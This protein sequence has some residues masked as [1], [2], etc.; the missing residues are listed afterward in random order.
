[1]RKVIIEIELTEHDE[2]SEVSESEQLL[3]SEARRAVD[4][5][6]APYSDFKVGAAVLLDSGD[7]VLGSNQ[8]NAAYPSGLCAERVA[9]FA[10]KSQFPDR[11][12]VAVAIA[13]AM[14]EIT[15]E[16]VAPCGG[17]RQVFAEYGDRQQEPIVLLLVAGSQRVTRY[18]DARL[19]LP[20]RFSWKDLKKGK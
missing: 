15:L 10:A 13:T 17:C 16:P 11:A 14:G 9:L 20:G 6:Y 1:M 7:I 3:M 19:L 5:A 4:T 8:E 18:S 2:W 12:I